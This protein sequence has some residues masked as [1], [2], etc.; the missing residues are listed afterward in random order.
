MRA[1]GVLLSAALLAA[2]A[3]GCANPPAPA[4]ARPPGPAG[5]P[6]ATSGASAPT[7]PTVLADA[8]LPRIPLAEFSNGLLPR[9]VLDDHGIALGGI[10][11]DLYPASAPD[12]YWM[13]TDRGPNGQVT[14]DGAERRT[15]PVP[16]FDPAVLR[17]RVDGPVLRVL[18]AI[19]IT[20]TDGQAVTGLSNTAG[21]DESP[22]DLTGRTLLPLHPGG[23]DTEGLVRTG[24]G[25]FWVSEEYSPSIVHLSSS[26]RVLA[27]YVPGG[28]ALLD[29]GYP[30]FP[31]L[32]A[33]LSHRQ[34]NR[35]FESLALSPDGHTL[36]AALQSP[37][38]LPGDKAGKKAGSRSRAVRV[39]AL[40]TAS[41][42]PTAEYVYPLQDVA[43]FDPS[44]DGD[45]SA[46]K[47]S[48]MAWYG[49][50]Q[51]LVDERTDNVAKLYLVRLS[52]ATNVLGG[53]FDS[54]THTPALEQ[55]DL[56]ASSVTPLGKT[57]L[58]DLTAQV[59]NLPK[60]IEGLAVR[61]P[62]T[63]AVAND[64]DFG[65]TDGAGAFGPDGRLR[66]SG[67]P[68]RLLVLRLP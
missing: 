51:L 4:P 31:T 42:R 45:E 54:A 61:D 60:K 19:P 1:S 14:V 36:Y 50:D 21:R 29:A 28:L 63:L 17:V 7:A 26:G 33:I 48:A 53:P 68:S 12:E 62:K 13:I 67:I 56:A 43:G 66:D 11:S 8:T 49:P 16:G 40:D 6:A 55:T 27:R 24:N 3:A 59:P 57:L 41:G 46:M 22:Y 52:G 23:L 39:L 15:F 64:N 34:G 10:G 9:A 30:V 65:M 47:I 20:A 38:A 32:P 35:G 37:L 5:P 44:A 2:C 25:E 58:I 18:Q